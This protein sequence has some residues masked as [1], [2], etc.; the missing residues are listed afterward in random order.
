MLK[1]GVS[2]TKKLAAPGQRKIW[3]L[4]ALNREIDNIFSDVQGKRTSSEKRK[5]LDVEMTDRRDRRPPQFFNPKEEEKKKAHSIGVKKNNGNV[6]KATT[7]RKYKAVVSS[8]NASHAK[9]PIVLSSKEKYDIKNGELQKYKN[10]LDSIGKY[11]EASEVVF[12]T[13]YR[14]TDTYRSKIEADIVKIVK[15]GVKEAYIQHARQNR[16]NSPSSSSLKNLQSKVQISTIVVTPQKTLKQLFDE[17]TKSIEDE[18]KREKET[19]KTFFERKRE[20]VVDKKRDDELSNI[21]GT[22]R[23]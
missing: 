10:I 19:G 3:N 13:Q 7:Q 21:F 17:I 8:T 20:K 15:R 11:V 23:F 6:R 14:V 22:L 1:G 5:G 4:K 16:M 12:K 9:N 18:I 2:H